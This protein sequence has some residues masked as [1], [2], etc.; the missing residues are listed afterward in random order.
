MNLVSSTQH[1]DKSAIFQYMTEPLIRAMQHCRKKA[2]EPGSREEGSAEV[3]CRMSVSSAV[4]KSSKA[5]IDELMPLVRPLREESAIRSHSAMTLGR[6]VR[7]M[8]KRIRD[9]IN[10]PIQKHPFDAL[11]DEGGAQYFQHSIWS[12]EHRPQEEEPDAVLS[13]CIRAAFP[14]APGESLESI[15]NVLDRP[16][17]KKKIDECGNR[18]VIQQAFD[19]FK[20]IDRWDYD[21]IQLEIIT[22]GNALFYTTYALLYKLDLVAYFNLDDQVVRNFLVAVQAAYHPNPYHNAMHGADVT[23]INYYIIMVAGLCDKCKLS[24]EEILAALIGGAVHDFDHPGLNN[25]FHSRTNSF[26]ATLYNDRSI[27][28]NHH[29]ACTFELIR[30]NRYN[31]FATLT[32]EQYQVVRDTMVD[33]VL[34]TDMGNHAKIFKNFTVRMSETQDWS[35][36]KEDVRL[37]LSM[38]IKMADIS[39]CARP[40]HIYAEWAKNISREFYLQ[41]DAERKVNLSISPFMD[42]SKEEEEFPKGQISFMMYIVQ[43]MIEAVSEFLP[44]LAFAVNLCNE[45]K[46]YWKRKQEE[47][48][49]Q[50]GGGI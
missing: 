20:G 31:I 27:L 45:N 47:A 38:S 23:Q 40:N 13:E 30:I 29:L 44:R 32:P 43:P 18:Y 16:E 37:A 36:K 46:E 4:I 5:K 28:E 15:S 26:L 6:D 1:P 7:N 10:K 50:D 24:K 2:T 22:N 11:Y 39:N 42:R 41:G 14:I 35:T 34:A 3:E 49:I 8:E 25:N 17:L 19:I 33:M 48:A 12:P 21:T 9:Q